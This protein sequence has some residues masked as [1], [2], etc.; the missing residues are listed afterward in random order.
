MP[1]VEPSHHVDHVAM[2]GALEQTAC[3]HAAI[4]AFAVHRNRAL[5]I[6][7][8]QSLRKSM[9]RAPLRFG[10]VTRLPFTLAAHVE[11]VK[12]AP[13]PLAQ[14]PTQFLD[15]NL[16]RLQHRQPSLLPRRHPAGEITTE[17]FNAHAS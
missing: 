9:E 7:C 12:S 8:G 11:D 2:T 13:A 14:F 10:D 4:S 1:R 16:R 5:R 6:D 3:D 17:L 15:G